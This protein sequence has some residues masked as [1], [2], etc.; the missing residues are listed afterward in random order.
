MKSILSYLNMSNVSHPAP[1]DLEIGLRIGEAMSASLSKKISS[2]FDNEYVTFS[3]KNNG[4]ETVIQVLSENKKLQLS[5]S[6]REF[7][8]IIIENESTTC[9]LETFTPT[10][11]GKKLELIYAKI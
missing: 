3:C 1:S 4:F 5:L 8:A 9:V 10:T 11:F 7:N 2:I 6:E